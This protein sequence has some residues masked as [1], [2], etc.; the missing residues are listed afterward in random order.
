[1]LDP[2]F[3]ADGQQI[4]YVRNFD[5][6]RIEL[7]SNTERA[8]TK[9]GSEAKGHGL[10]EFVAQ[11]EMSRYSGYWWSPDAKQVAYAEVDNTPVEELTIVDPMHPEKGADTFH[12]PRA[13]K[14]NA[15]VRVGVTPAAGGKTTWV[16]WDAKRYPYVAT[17]VWPKKGPLTLLV[18]NREQ[19]EQVLLAADV[20]TGKTRV[21]LTETD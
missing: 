11:E 17:V 6:H 15:V 21:L 10:A 8:V 5:L 7:A 3:S 4:A 12:Y 9:G 14:A 19:T 13:G 16:T 2:K 1:V 18:Q 20:A